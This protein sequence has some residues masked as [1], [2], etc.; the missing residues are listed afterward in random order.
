MTK[1][2]LK[3]IILALMVIG[4]GVFGG[5]KLATKEVK[6]VVEPDK[7]LPSADAAKTDQ[8]KPVVI[9]EE[10]EPEPIEVVD[11]RPVQLFFYNP[12]L[13]QDASGNVACTSAGLVVVA[14]DIPLTPTPIADTVRYLL[15]GYL[16]EA[17][18]RAGVTTEFPLLD[19]SLQSAS[20]TGGVLTLVFNDPQA[21]SNG[22]ACRVN[23]L[24][25]QVEAT[26]RQFAGVNQV[27]I[28]PEAGVFQP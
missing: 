3:I 24:R 11:T 13:D 16:E 5:Y 14:R 9:E 20:L 17:E 1:F 21:K 22:G 25:A 15:E 27:R 23:V 28:L 7:E 18:W 4:L 26:A 8:I 19:F 2:G 6:T 12:N 10:P